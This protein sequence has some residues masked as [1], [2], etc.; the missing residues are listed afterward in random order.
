MSMQANRW[1]LSDRQV[2]T[3]V[4]RATKKRA[5]K[6]A[7]MFVKGPVPMWWMEKAHK[8]GGS[9][10]WLGLLAWHKA[11]MGCESM[12]ASNAYCEAYGISKQAKRRAIKAL[13]DAGLMRIVEATNHASPAI[14]LVREQPA[15]GVDEV[16]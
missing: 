8:L 12:K 11:G 5:K 9:A 3:I 7:E 2:V 15:D 1:A 4:S 16:A 13:A 6:R 10:L 14:E